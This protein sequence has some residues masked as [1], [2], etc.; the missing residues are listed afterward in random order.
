MSKSDIIRELAIRTTW[1]E[2]DELPLTMYDTDEDGNFVGVDV[3]DGG[4][5]WLKFRDASGSQKLTLRQTLWKQVTRIDQD[6]E[7]YTEQTYD[8]TG[9]ID[10]MLRTNILVGGVL[11]E[12]DA[13]SNKIVE[14]ELP[15]KNRSQFIKMLSDGMLAVIVGMAMRFLYS[16]AEEEVVDDA[17]N[18]QSGSVTPGDVTKTLTTKPSS[19]KS[20]DAPASQL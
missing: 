9:F 2:S 6:G 14:Y 16:D 18:L 5:Y 17:K 1:C 19:Q 10:A 13:A 4:R 20:L 7:E 12:Q 3:S 15:P 11:P 8:A